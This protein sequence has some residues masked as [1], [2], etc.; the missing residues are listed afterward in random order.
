[1]VTVPLPESCCDADQATVWLWSGHAAYE[2]PSLQLDVHSGSVHCFA[3]GLDAPFLLRSEG[4]AE[5]QVRSALIPARTPHQLV[6][7]TGRMVFFYVDPSAPGAAGLDEQLTDRSTTI[8]VHHR[9]EAAL[10][11]AWRSNPSAGPELLR[12][13][14]LGPVDAAPVDVRVRSAM[15]L[16][17]S[18]PADNASAAEIA[19]AVGLSTSRF[20][21]LFS[22]S[23]G[24]SFRR[25][26]MWARM[27]HAA[28]ALGDGADLTTAAIAAGFSSPSHFSDTF[29]AMF[30]LSASALLAGPT[31]LLIATDE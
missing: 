24:T 27:C 31:R 5:R 18:Q 7:D 13:R 28:G 1:M 22:A 6:A 19:A 26:R 14:L 23:A 10:I 9:D 30:G 11:S 20:L 12:R 17:R 4:T 8:T 15:R 2:G 21:H 29:R 25:Y 16:L 3:L